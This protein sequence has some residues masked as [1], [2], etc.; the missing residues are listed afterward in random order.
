[1]YGG[2]YIRWTWM[3]NGDLPLAPVDGVAF[4]IKGRGRCRVGAAKGVPR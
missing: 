1:M 3:L 2:R 4:G